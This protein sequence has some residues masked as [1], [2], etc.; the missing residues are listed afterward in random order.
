MIEMET[1]NKESETFRLEYH[2]KQE[3]FHLA[4]IDDARLTHTGWMTL[5]EKIPETIALEFIEYAHEN[6]LA[7]NQYYTWRM[8]QKELHKWLE[9][10]QQTTDYTQPGNDKPSLKTQLQ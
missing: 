3:N 4:D 5:M 10:Q 6:L 2:S 9:K 7:T 8:M 1:V